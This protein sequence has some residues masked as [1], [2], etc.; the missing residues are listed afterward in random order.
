[1]RSSQ[2][3]VVRNICPFFLRL[4]EAVTPEW[5]FSS[6][7]GGGQRFE[8]CFA[9]HTLCCRGA[10]DLLLALKTCAVAH[11][12]ERLNILPNKKQSSR[13]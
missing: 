4:M 5:A 2:S 3:R 6:L 7:Q 8:P 9:H 13:N 1:M 10:R 11:T 12:F